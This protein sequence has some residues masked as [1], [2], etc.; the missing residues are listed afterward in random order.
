M[1]NKRPYSVPDDQWRPGRSAAHRLGQAGTI[2]AFVKLSINW[3]K[4]L[5]IPEDVPKPA[6]V[7]AAHVLAPPKAS[8]G[9]PILSPG[10]PDAPRVAR[11]R[12]ATLRDFAELRS[13]GDGEPNESD[14]ALAVMDKLEP[15]SNYIPSPADPTKLVALKGAHTQSEIEQLAKKESKVFM[16]ARSGFERGNLSSEIPKVVTLEMYSKDMYLYKGCFVVGSEDENVPFS[17]VGDSGAL[18]YSKE[19][20]AVGFVVGAKGS[21]TYFYPAKACLT[22]MDVSLL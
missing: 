6:F 5:K 12:R 16:I 1:N 22:L 20:K 15:V 18:V 21:R 2:G 17:F 13:N 9:D 14:I 8:L 11:N 10:P 4:K 3:R 7:G 19:C